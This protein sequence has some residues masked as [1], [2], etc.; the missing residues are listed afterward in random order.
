MQPPPVENLDDNS[1]NGIHNDQ[2][3]RSIQHFFLNIL[4]SSMDMLV[5]NPILLLTSLK[6]MHLPGREGGSISSAQKCKSLLW[7]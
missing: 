5:E 3:D 4:T 6:K 1:E 7:T 2:E